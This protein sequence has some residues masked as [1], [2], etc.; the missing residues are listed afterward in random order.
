MYSLVIVNNEEIKEAKAINKNVV[1]SISLQELHWFGNKL[2]RI[3][4]YDVLK[5][6]CLVLMGKCILLMMV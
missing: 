5:S 3:V 2:H 6:L 4:T 1:K